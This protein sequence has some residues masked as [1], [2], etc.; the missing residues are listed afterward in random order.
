MAGKARIDF[1]NLSSDQQEE[2]EERSAILEYDH[3]MERQEAEMMARIIL[4]RK[5]Y[6]DE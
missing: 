6:A 2:F 1:K 3:G 5:E 4:L